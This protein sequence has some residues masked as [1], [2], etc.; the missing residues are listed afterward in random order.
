MKI[1]IFFTFFIASCFLE[2]SG[3]CLFNGQ[4]TSSVWL[5]HSS[6][7]NY[8]TISPNNK[9]CCDWDNHNCYKESKVRNPNDYV[10]VY[11]ACGKTSH[12]FTNVKVYAGGSMIVLKSSVPEFDN[13]LDIFDENGNKRYWYRCGTNDWEWY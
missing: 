3:Y 11:V 4:P 6:T 8:E 5:G 2:V 9:T 1:F 10:T 7:V 12:H 13:F